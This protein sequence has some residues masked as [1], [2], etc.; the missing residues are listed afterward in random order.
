MSS[1]AYARK[2]VVDLLEEHRHAQLLDASAETRKDVAELRGDIATAL[3][4]ILLNLT[5]AKKEDIRAWITE[6]LRR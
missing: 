2:L 6:N 4:M 1:G 5:S 3:E